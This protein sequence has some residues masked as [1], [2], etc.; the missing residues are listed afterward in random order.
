MQNVL[1]TQKVTGFVPA[2]YK[3]TNTAEAGAVKRFFSWFATQED[4]RFM[5]AALTLLGQ[6]G[7]ALPCAL[8]SIVYFGG[9][10]F[11]LWILACVVN[12]PS[13]ALTLAAQPTKV[14]LPAL[15]L[16][17]AVNAGIILFSLAS[18]LLA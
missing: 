9:N 5:W 4:K 17:W 18:Y 7:L 10:N 15:F 16:A 13:L 6:I 2:T 11:A 12:V 14:T 3:K 8:F 1:T